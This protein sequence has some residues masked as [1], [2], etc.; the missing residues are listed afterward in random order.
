[1]FTKNLNL[2]ICGF[3]YNAVVDLF[4]FTKNIFERKS[5]KKKKTESNAF[6]DNNEKMNQN[7]FG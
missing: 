5:K 3:Y 6:D 2:S 4:K 1:M 7:R